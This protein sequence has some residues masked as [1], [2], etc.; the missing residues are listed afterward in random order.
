MAVNIRKLKWKTFLMKYTIVKTIYSLE[1]QGQWINETFIH[2]ESSM[3]TNSIFSG[4]VPVL[5][6]WGV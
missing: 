6:F 2:T 3:T 4:E 1:Q 5:E